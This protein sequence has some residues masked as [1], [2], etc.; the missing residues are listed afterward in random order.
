[1]EP[2]NGELP[3]QR[4]PHDPW[5]GVLPGQTLVP[6]YLVSRYAAQYRAIVDVLLIAQ[7]TSLTG[8]SFDDIEQGLRVRLA[9]LR[10]E[11]TA[12]RLLSDPSFNLE[13]RLDRLFKWQVI[14]RWQEPARTGEDFLRRRDRYQL[15][16]LAAG[17]HLF[18]ADADT[19]ED[20]SS[21]VT[22]APRA[23]FER[24]VAFGEAIAERRYPAAANE[25]Q[26]V[27]ALHH[28]MARAARGWQRS[29]AHNLSG[30]PDETKQES[31]WQTLLAYVGMWGEQVD[32][33]SPRIASLLTGLDDTLTDQVWRACVR[34]ALPAGSE[35][36]MVAEQAIR[37]RN[38]WQA[39]GL[40]FDGTDGQARRLRRQ[41]R[42]VV[43]PWARNTQF[44]MQSGGVVSRRAELIELASAIDT[45]PDDAKAWRVWDTAVGGFAA[46]HLLLAADAPDDHTA[47]W[48]S[49]P[50]APVTARYREQGPRAVVGRR[51]RRADFAAGREAARRG[52][53]ARQAARNAA[54]ASL[55]R[56]SGA[57]LSQW[58]ALEESEFELLLD[59]L[60]T[61]R[62]GVLDTDSGTAEGVTEDGRWTVRLRSPQ[63]P[64]ATARV[65]GPHGSLVTVDWSV[66]MTV[67][68]ARR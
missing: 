3:E 12:E 68:E 37:W 59:L 5:A 52:R 54:E 14:T 22:L 25:F 41:L 33:F 62:R 4:E 42:D 45:A 57:S 51:P 35:D 18:W 19:A 9:E 60:S 38:T 26:Q 53:L 20:E 30:A 23:I 49:A 10:G 17:L 11:A 64:T 61:A 13:G 66:E 43:A 46:R 28:A 27:S 47:S 8:M 50:P 7:E 44:L 55:R 34:C 39:L 1:M 67:T 15:T 2:D 56:L 16:P 21:D 65:R 31:V 6:A 48:S 29:L 58:P 36:T 40:W 32:V 63:D 24:L